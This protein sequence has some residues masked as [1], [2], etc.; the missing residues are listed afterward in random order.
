MKMAIVLFLLLC[1]LA[2]AREPASNSQGNSRSIRAG[3]RRMWETV[4]MEGDHSQKASSIRATQ[5]SYRVFTSIKFVG[6]TRR[7]VIQLLGDPQKS[8]DSIYNFP[9][10]PASKDKLVYRFD[11]G[12]GGWQFNL[13]FDRHDRVT[14]VTPLAIG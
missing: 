8:S 13:T 12:S 1:T 4:P 9:F 3:I 2:I 10:Y 14:K 6:M 7:E 11:T 5:A